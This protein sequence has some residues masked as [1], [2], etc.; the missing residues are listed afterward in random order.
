MDSFLGTLAK[1]KKCSPDSTQDSLLFSNFLRQC[2]QIIL[3]ESWLSGWLATVSHFNNEST[4]CVKS[5]CLSISDWALTK[6]VSRSNRKSP[7]FTLK[8]SHYLEKGISDI[9]KMTVTYW[10]HWSFSKGTF[11]MNSSL[12]PSVR[13]CERI[14]RNFRHWKE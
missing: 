7:V 12:K 8:V 5:E 6:E 2:R 10:Q 3:V 4:D 14:I 1:A 13:W 11:K 9:Y